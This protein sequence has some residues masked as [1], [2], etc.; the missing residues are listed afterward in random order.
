MLIAVA[1]LL[2]GAAPARAADHLMRVNEA[3]LDVG[4]AQYVELLDPAGEPFPAVSYDLAVYDGAG[5]LQ[6]STPISGPTVAFRTTPVL[7]ASQPTVGGQTRDV[8]LNGTLPPSGQA[9]FRRGGSAF[10]HCLQWGTVTNPVSSLAEAGPAPASGQSLQRCPGGG[11]ALGSPTPKAPNSCGTS[12]P[13]PGSGQGIASPDRSRPVGSLVL[14]R[15][16]L[17]TARVRGY[18]F[19]VRSSE[20]GRA[21][22]QLLRRGRVVATAAG[23]MRANIRRE[24]TLRFSR[25][26]RRALAPLRS[27]TLVLRVRVFDL[28]GNVRTLIRAVHLA[29]AP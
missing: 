19:R 13:G 18:R 3:G 9:C 28:A 4:G 25:A 27:V 24:L 6:S 29:R 16:T 21:V 5:A 15:H 2:A 22:A 23:A 7:V 26:G 12:G 17:A 8:A 11:A 14:R 10:I 1:A 20:S